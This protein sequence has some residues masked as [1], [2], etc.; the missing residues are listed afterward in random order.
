MRQLRE[1][2]RLRLHADLSM[3]QIKSSLRVSLGAVQKVCS[4]AQAQNL[5]WEAI[6]KLDDQ[7]LAKLF[8]PA[9]DTRA[10]GDFELPDWAVG[11]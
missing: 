7:Q 1:I 9:A 2:L 10:T 3:R 11:G 6:E 5:R 4:K 8:Y